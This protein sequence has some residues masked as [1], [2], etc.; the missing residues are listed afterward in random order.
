M[1]IPDIEKTAAES[2]TTSVL[3]GTSLPDGEI[4]SPALVQ[5][6]EDLGLRIYDGDVVDWHSQSPGHPRNW[7]LRK[8]LCNTAWIFLLDSFSD[9]LQSGG[10][11]LL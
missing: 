10:V 9:L 7:P 5:K 1:S 2:S 11:R 3:S 8:K 4:I 6:V